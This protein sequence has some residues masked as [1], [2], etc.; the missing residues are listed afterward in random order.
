MAIRAL[1]TREPP[2]KA[3]A[4][5]CAG[6][7]L[8]LLSSLAA[9]AQA[10]AQAQAQASGAPHPWHEGVS[11]ERKRRAIELFAQAREL[12]RQMMLGEAR[13]KYEEALAQW[14]HPDLRFYLGR[15]LK[16]MGLPLLAH[17]SLRLSMRW[18]PGSLE[19]EDYAEARALMQELVAREL[20]VMELR[21][22][23]PGAAVL[24]DGKP[25]FVGPGVAERFLMPGE[26]VI[27]VKKEEYT[28]LTATVVTYA[29]ARASRVLSVDRI[30]TERPWAAWVPWSVIGAGAGLGVAGGVLRWQAGEHMDEAEQQFEA[31]CGLRCGPGRSGEYSRSRTESHVAVGLFIAAGATLATGAALVYLNR[32]RSY[33]VDDQ[34]GVKIEMAP[35]AS[36]AEVGLSAR[37]FF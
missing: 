2:I 35:G 32:P 25:W 37:L 5:L 13:A 17:E 19:P 28:P 1:P 26:H 30:V 36:D 6:L 9:P 34:S 12:H 11:A 18:G 22:D 31:S 23:E 16:T 20:A 8:A 29:G 4:A 3:R 10:Q 7:T 21:C 24:L 33:R 27:T 15:V 14:E